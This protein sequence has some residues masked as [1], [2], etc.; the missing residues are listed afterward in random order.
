M[1]DAI[2]ELRIDATADGSRLFIKA[3]PGAARSKIVGVLGDALKVAVAAPAEGGKANREIIAILADALRVRRSD[4]SITSGATT[5][6]KQ[7]T[8][9]GLLPTA[10]RDRLA[11]ALE[12]TTKL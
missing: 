8:I 9:A 3:V 6:R 11:A 4:V 1:G 10:L 5:A 7:I 12:S 2:D